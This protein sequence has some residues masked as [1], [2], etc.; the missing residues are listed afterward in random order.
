MYLAARGAR[1]VVNNR[2]RPGTE[3]EREA[4]V[5][6][7]ESIEL[8]GGVSLANTMDITH[9]GASDAIVAAALDHFGQLDIVI[10]NAGI[11][12]HSLFENCPSEVL[13]EMINV[14]LAG[15]W[16]LTQAAWPHLRK[17]RGRVVMTVSR[18]SFMGHDNHA[19]YA[20]TK[21]AIYGLT[22]ALA[23]EGA[24]DGVRVNAISPRAW[25][26]MTAKHD[27]YGIN[28]DPDAVAAMERER[29]PELT[30]PVM[31]ALAHES[32]PFNGEVF[33]AWAGQVN[34]IFTAYTQGIQTDLSFTA[35]DFVERRDEIQDEHGYEAFGLYRGRFLESGVSGSW[36]LPP[37]TE[38]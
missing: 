30:C 21:A 6:V 17:R 28:H 5:E 1:V 25:T 4:A 32:C 12:N 3:R 13:D 15:S 10:N 27:S 33:G 7:A 26:P 8:A 14:H 20:A 11:A 9:P 31:T 2:I 18:A 19:A 34:R 22:R 23:V 35:R 24:R 36:P 16:F 37:G 38:R 29:P